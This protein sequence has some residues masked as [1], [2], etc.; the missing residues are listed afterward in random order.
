MNQREHL[1]MRGVS[2]KLEW[3]I[4]VGDIEGKRL[5]QSS[6]FWLYGKRIR[7]K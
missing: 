3:I 5:Y 6:H 1:I 2:G 7:R 4:H